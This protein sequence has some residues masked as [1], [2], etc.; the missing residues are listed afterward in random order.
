MPKIKSWFNLDYLAKKISSIDQKESLVNYPINS[1]EFK[2]G[3]KAKHLSRQIDLL[4]FSDVM[5]AR[6]SVVFKGFKISQESIYGGVA[7][8][9]FGFKK[10][11]NFFRQ[12]YFRCRTIKIDKAVLVSDS[13]SLINYYHW[14]IQLLLRL[15]SVLDYIKDDFKIIL[16]YSK[17]KISDDVIFKTLAAFG[18]KNDC[19]IFMQRNKKLKVKKLIMP[20][21]AGESEQ[22]FQL[23]NQVKNQIIN[24]YAD[25]LNF[26]L[27]KKIYISRSKAIYRKIANENEVMNA[28]SRYG[29]V[30]VNMEDYSFLEQI[31]IAH[32]A[33]CIIS[34]HGAGLTNI[35]FMKENSCV[36]ELI[37]ENC[38][39]RHFYHIAA[40]IGLK[41]ILQKCKKLAPVKQGD[42]SDILVDITELEANL[43]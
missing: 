11:F 4:E 6:Q 27:G 33:D 35:L 8:D 40:A 32:N 37:G 9:Y 7:Q 14:N 12:N 41:Y 5:V 20:L 29:F 25:Q 34:C 22:N 24:F 16:P 43:K 13:W 21:N 36:I 31:S 30:A 15:V 28:L 19:L 38:L 42:N 2:N 18:I 23:T 1:V 17:Y 3:V 10:R 26:N 39:R